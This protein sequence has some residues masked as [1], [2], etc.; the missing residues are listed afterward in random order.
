MKKLYI[1]DLDGTLLTPEGKIS[2]YSLERLN[3]LLD[4]GVYFTVATARSASTAVHILENLHLTLPVILM[5][6]IAVYDRNAGKYVENEAMEHD[7]KSNIF[8]VLDREKSPAFVYAIKDDKLYCYAP[9]FLNEEMKQFRSERE[10][11]YNKVFTDID[12]YYDLEDEDI[13]Y[14]T[15]VGKKTELENVYEA[16]RSIPGVEALFYEDVY[17]DDWFIEIH[18]EGVSKGSAA[19]AI[20]NEV[21]ADELVVF[22]DNL[23]DLPMIQVADYAYVVENGKDKVKALADEVI[24][25]NTE[26]SVVK[27]LE[28]IIKQEGEE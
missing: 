21:G 18:E 5:N 17:T 11:L 13:I 16:V 19:L 23:N 20:K 28:K 25:K 14:F 22:G 3:A 8:H 24:G 15:L 10:R 7:I 2:S 1:S 6:G 12:S 26:D 4:Q 9:P 27:V